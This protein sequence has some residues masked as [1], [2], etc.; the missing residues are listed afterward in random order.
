MGYGVTLLPEAAARWTAPD[1]QAR[2]GLPTEIAARA[3]LAA[4]TAVTILA[5]ALTLVAVLARMA[6]N[7]RRLADWETD[8]LANGPRWT[9]RP[10]SDRE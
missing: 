4:A 7:R 6:L 10:N 1:G 8:W 5:V 3:S 9:R 2:T